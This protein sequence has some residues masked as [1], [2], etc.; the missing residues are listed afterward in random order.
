[1]SGFGFPFLVCL[2]SLGLRRFAS[3]LDRCGPNRLT[4]V[5]GGVLHLRL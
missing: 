3:A 5:Q 4:P 2:D 1:M